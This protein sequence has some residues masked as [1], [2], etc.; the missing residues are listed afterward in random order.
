MIKRKGI[1]LILLSLF[2]GGCSVFKPFKNQGEPRFIDYFFEDKEGNKITKPVSPK[3][4]FVYMVLLTEN[5]IGEKVTLDLEGKAIGF[6]YRGTY[7]NDKMPFK[8][9]YNKEKLRLYIY[10]YKNKRHRRLKEKA[11][12]RLKKKTTSTS[13]EKE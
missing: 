10:N 1:V 11:M 9:R 7:L 4:K 13:K 3:Q 8:I 12:K 6:I 5:A 2:L